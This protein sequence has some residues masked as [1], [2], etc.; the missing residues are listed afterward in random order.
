[1][2]EDQGC[3]LEP[4]QR[5]ADDQAAED[6]QASLERPRQEEEEDDE[7]EDLDAVHL[8][9]ATR[10]CA[11]NDASAKTGLLTLPSMPL[12]HCDDNFPLPVNPAETLSAE[13]LDTNGGVGL[14][15]DIA[16]P[17]QSVCHPY[18]PNS[19]EQDF[20]NGQCLSCSPCLDLSN[21]PHQECSEEVSFTQEEEIPTS[22]W[23]KDVNDAEQLELP[24]EKQAGELHEET[25]AGREEGAPTVGTSQSPVGTQS[26]ALTASL[27]DLLPSAD[28]QPSQESGPSQCHA[29]TTDPTGVTEPAR[30]VMALETPVGAVAT[31]PEAGGVHDG[32]DTVELD[33]R[34]TYPNRAVVTPTEETVF[35]AMEEEEG[36]RMPASLEHDEEIE[37]EEEKTDEEEERKDLACSSLDTQENRE[38]QVLPVEKEDPEQ[39]EDPTKV[40]DHTELPGQTDLSEQPMQVEQSEQKE[41]SEQVLVQTEQSEQME[42]S[43]QAEPLKRSEQVLVQMEQSE[44]MTQSEQTE[45]L[46]QSE[47]S[48]QMEQ[49]EQAEVLEQSEQMEQSEQVEVLEQSEQTQQMEESEQAEPLEQSE[50][51]EPLEQTQQMEQSEQAEEAVG[52]KQTEHLGQ[53]G[54]ME[55]A[56]TPTPKQTLQPAPPQQTKDQTEHKKQSV[57]HA[58]GGCVDREEACRLAERLYRLHGI[59][60]T[61]VVRHL[62]K[63]NEFSQVV[64]EEYLKY[65]DFTGQSLD[66]ALRSF[67]KVVVLIGET[68]ERERVLE[69]FS[70]R[71]HQCNP[72]SFSSPGA[73]L[74]LTCALML[75]NTDLHGQN[76]GKAMT[77]SAF[78]SNLDG[79]DEGENFRRELLK[80]LYNSIKNEPLEWAVDEEELKSSMVLPG[81]DKADTPLRSKSNPFQD[82]PHDKKATVYKQGFLIRKAHADIDGK[83]TPWGKRSWKTFYAVLKGMVLYL[84]KN[85]YRIEWQSSEEVIS[86]HHALAE[87]ADDYTKRPHVFRLQTADWRVFLF[88]ASTAEQMSSWICRINLVSALYSSPPFPAAVGS[89]KRFSRPILPA[90]QSALTLEKQLQSHIRML[91]SF[92]S[93]LALLLQTPP[94]GRKFKARELEDRRMREEYL[95]HERSR[96]EVYKQMLEVWKGIG[97]TVGEPVGAADLERFDGELCMEIGEQEEEAALKKSHSSPSLNLEPAPPPVVKVRRNISERRTYRKI[98]IPRRNREV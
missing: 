94:E 61:D 38:K 23:A 89:Q 33:K 46:E 22:G 36:R 98:I 85:E 49:S 9:E 86:V 1:M 7:G 45:V 75:L 95:L 82:V 64:G 54:Q 16:D 81:D 29:E 14:N 37:K 42:E 39:T 69:R 90:S 77:M 8:G 10:E 26:P 28:D 72:E 76:V 51:T 67:L 70:H 53:T 55:P 5:D 32:P 21:G 52:P 88:Q 74:T 44:R 15:M 84:Q 20:S 2:E 58:N 80:G 79:M 87:R 4:D 96:Y 47:Q 73:V 65:F 34:D 78:V 31:D 27:Q 91:D 25:E 83:R 3:A 40:L 63:D 59:R 97:G 62:N 66:E 17:G 57:S 71:F 6:M 19:V 35:S 41:E 24:P 93:D 12:S 43:E 48:E 30:T 68:Q 13:E 56:D 11:V 50:Q 18:P 60:R 92:S